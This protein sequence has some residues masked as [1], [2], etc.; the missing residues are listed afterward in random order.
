MFYFTAAL[1]FGIFLCGMPLSLS[2][3]LNFSS[4]CGE[5]MIACCCSCRLSCCR[6]CVNCFCTLHVLQQNLFSVISS[7]TT[8]T[9]VWNLKLANLGV[10]RFGVSWEFG[11]IWHLLYQ[12][13]YRIW[14]NKNLALLLYDAKEFRCAKIFNAQKWI[15]TTGGHW[16]KFVYGLTMQ[17]WWRTWETDLVPVCYLIF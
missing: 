7:F 8:G 1:G 16:G 11:S 15:I 17:T 14:N 13:S 12:R 9:W 4:N 6:S 5:V 2:V 10:T 3:S